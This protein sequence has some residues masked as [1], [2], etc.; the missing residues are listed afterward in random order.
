MSAAP[1][2]IDITNTYGAALIGVIFSAMLY[3]ITTLQTGF[4]YIH[5]P[6]DRIRNKI[7]V[8]TV[9]VLDTI[10]MILVCIAIYHA[11]ITS[12]A[13]PLALVAIHWSQTSSSICNILTVVIVHCFFTVQ[14][15]RL[16]GPK[17]RW[18]LG[19]I[20]GL[21]VLGQFCLGIEVVTFMFIKKDFEKLREVTFIAIVPFIVISV[22]SDIAI[23]AALCIL[24][25]GAKSHFRRTNQLLTTIM[26][27]AINR[28][29]LTL[30][31]TIA[32][33][34]AF[35]ISPHTL[36]YLAIDFV[37]GKLYANSL[38]A[39]LNQRHSLNPSV[40]RVLLL[41]MDSK[42]CDVTAALNFRIPDQG[43]EI[44]QPHEPRYILESASVY[45]AQVS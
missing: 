17:V 31:V 12:Y 29:I 35:A 42:Q 20:N 25:H 37:V 36:W 9:W 8:G 41:E 43:I 21:L 3:G 15:F 7:L 18:W 38:L 4:F 44:S 32:E 22:L 10:H 39:T 6:D 16:S 40:H 11:L 33:V 14:I 19:T 28:C 30:V 1:P 5:Y 27:Y 23:T 2:R 34:I 26:V 24:L 45:E 13:N